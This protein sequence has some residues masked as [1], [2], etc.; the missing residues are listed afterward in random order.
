M[1]SIPNLCPVHWN[2][3][4]QDLSFLPSFL[5]STQ[6]SDI[7]IWTSSACCSFD[8]SSIGQVSACVWQS[9]AAAW[10]YHTAFHQAVQRRRQ[11]ASDSLWQDFAHSPTLYF[12]FR[13][14]PPLTILFYFI[15]LRQSPCYSQIVCSRFNI[16]LAQIFFFVCVRLPFPVPVVSLS[17]LLLSL[18]FIVTLSK[19]NCCF[20][21]ICKLL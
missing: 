11:I 21:H 15:F 12:L 20:H 13:V 17:F 2:N 4:K 5:F 14:S 6:H 7:S 16:F 10:E 1:S 9:P 8:C 18:L 3:L 19:R